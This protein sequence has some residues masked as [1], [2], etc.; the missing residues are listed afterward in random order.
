ML[1]ELLTIKLSS[2][3][4]STKSNDDKNENPIRPGPWSQLYSV[5]MEAKKIMGKSGREST[6]KPN[7]KIILGMF[8]A[9]L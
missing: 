6:A 4:S 1:S 7:K 9:A 5:C 2:N 3:R 8:H